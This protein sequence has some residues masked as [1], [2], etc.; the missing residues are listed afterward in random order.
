L[1]LGGLEVD[2]ASLFPFKACH[3]IL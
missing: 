3:S 1:E 2:V